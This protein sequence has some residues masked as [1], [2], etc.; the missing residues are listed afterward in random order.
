MEGSPRREFAGSLRQQRFSRCARDV[1]RTPS[2]R[3]R[4][5]LLRR[6]ELELVC[7]TQGTNKR[8]IYWQRMSLT[9]WGGNAAATCG[10]MAAR[11]LF[12]A[13][14]LCDHYKFIQRVHQRMS[15]HCAGT[16]SLQ[17]LRPTPGTKLQDEATTKS[18]R[19]LSRYQKPSCKKHMYR[20]ISNACH[21]LSILSYLF[22]PGVQLLIYIRGDTRL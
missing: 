13:V 12:R 3:Y 14:L 17:I 15:S 2:T 9:L 7:S 20:P 1:C 8:A 16:P 22:S 21:S 6:T 19:L 18:I 5:S 4:M 10:A 11:T